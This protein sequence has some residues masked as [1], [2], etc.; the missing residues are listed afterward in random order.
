MLRVSLGVLHSA[1]TTISPNL[2][3]PWCSVRAFVHAWRRSVPATSILRICAASP[4]SPLRR[5]P[6]SR[7][8]SPPRALT[9]SRNGPT[10]WAILPDSFAAWRLKWRRGSVG[11]KTRSNN[12]PSPSTRGKRPP[13]STRSRSPTISEISRRVPVTSLTGAPPGA[14]IPT[15]GQLSRATPSGEDHLHS[16]VPRRHGQ[17]ECHGQPRGVPCGCWEASDGGRHRHP[18][19]RDSYVVRTQGHQ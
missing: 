7:G 6:S 1:P 3:I 9:R 17:V 11:S 8:N 19:A 13:R 10:P 14:A 18:V 2:T 15:D 4:E 5:S 12:S 16:L